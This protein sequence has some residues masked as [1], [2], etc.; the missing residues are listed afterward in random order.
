M[1]SNCIFKAIP[2]WLRHWKDGAELVFVHTEREYAWKIK[3]PH[4]F[5]RFKNGV[6]AHWVPIRGDL[7]RYPLPLFRGYWLWK[8]STRHMEKGVS[9][10]STEQ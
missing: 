1:L 3:F 2:L 7:G 10:G 4:C 8:K 5:V 6:E 9:Y